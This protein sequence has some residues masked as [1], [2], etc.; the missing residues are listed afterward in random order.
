MTKR[1]ISLLLVLV[2]VAVALVSMVS[3]G[4]EEDP[5]PDEPNKPDKPSTSDKDDN[6]PWAKVNF[7]DRKGNPYP[8][9]MQLSTSNAGG[10]MESGGEKYM[11]GPDESSADPV[12][13]AVRKRNSDAERILGIDMSY[14]Y[15]DKPWGSIKGAIMETEK[16]G[17]DIPDLYCDMIHDM[18]GASVENAVFK[19]LYRYTT[20]NLHNY[21]DNYYEE[22]YF[23]FEHEKGYYTDLMADMSLTG[24]KQF[25]IA[26]DFFLDVI[27][28]LI[29]LPFNIT[30]YGESVD[31]N[32]KEAFKL[33]E[34]VQDYN[35]TW[36]AMRQMS[37]LYPGGEENMDKN[38]VMAIAGGG[39]SSIALMYST[40]FTVFE[41]VTSGGKIVG[42]RMGDAVPSEF[43]ALFQKIADLVDEGGIYANSAILKEEDREGIRLCNE[44]FAKSGTSLFATPTMMGLLE[45]DI[46]QNMTDD[47]GILPLP[48]LQE[49]TSTPYCS[50]INGIG[51]VGAL[52]YHSPNGKEMSAYIQ[53]VTENSA[54][55]LTKYYDDAMKHKYSSDAGS[56]VML[57]LIYDSIG[58]QKTMMLEELM[59]SCNWNVSPHVWN[60]LL[61]SQNYTGN[62]TNIAQKYGECRDLKNNTLASIFQMWET[63]ADPIVYAD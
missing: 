10:E 7:A 2:M 34:M 58:S 37:S 35:W 23:N 15:I 49:G 53:Y 6:D 27:R 39:L 17:V 57:D 21:S 14:V 22:G 16:G 38:L 11:K 54:E 51:K 42:Y 1:L 3:C 44:K 8:L 46:F 45:E 60:N 48:K 50:I 25:L 32:D 28:A 63:K 36:D 59:V 52:S 40:S 13:E 55:V 30:M 29:L 31:V 62:A 24:D 12:L 47:M 41:E 19:N 26:S 18:L 61:Q 4:S 33:Y 20:E 9:I 56:Q 5:T 43:S